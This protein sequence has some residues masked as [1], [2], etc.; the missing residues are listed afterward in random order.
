M[1]T[2]IEEQKGTLGFSIAPSTQKI[3]CV[4]FSVSFCLFLSISKIQ[5]R[6]VASTATLLSVSL[7]LSFSLS[8]SLSLSPA[9][10]IHTFTLSASIAPHVYTLTFSCSHASNK[11]QSRDFE[12]HLLQL[13][14]TF[15]LPSMHLTSLCTCVRAC[16]C[17][18]VCVCVCVCVYVRTHMRAV[19]P[20]D[21]LQCI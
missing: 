16:V 13:L 7:P 17:M 12:L 14:C 2:C 19:V 8:L 11:L 5:R 3:L 9:S 20:V 1:C 15:N 18:C 6:C 21:T 10:T 4:Y